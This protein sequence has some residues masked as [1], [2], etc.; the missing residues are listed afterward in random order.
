MSKAVTQQV[1]LGKA[2]TRL[3]L[4]LKKSSSCGNFVARHENQQMCTSFQG[5]TCAMYNMVNISDF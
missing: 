3:F 1:K 2:G 5:C 4:S